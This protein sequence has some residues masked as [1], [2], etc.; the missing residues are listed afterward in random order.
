MILA[1]IAWSLLSL[2]FAH[3]VQRLIVEPFACDKTAHQPDAADTP[4]AGLIPGALEPAIDNGLRIRR[5]SH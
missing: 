3:A 4:E 1:P 2:A 5:V